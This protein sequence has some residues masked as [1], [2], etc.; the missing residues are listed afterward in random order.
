MCGLHAY[1][2]GFREQLW[3]DIEVAAWLAAVGPVFDPEAQTDRSAVEGPRKKKRASPKDP[4]GKP[5]G[6]IGVSP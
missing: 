6:A 1:L 4:F 3:P 5:H 2:T